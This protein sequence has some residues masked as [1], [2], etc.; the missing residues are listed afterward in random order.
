M[1]SDPR[2]SLREGDVIEFSSGWRSS[3]NVRHVVDR[4][5]A[6]FGAAIEDRP[7]IMTREERVAES[8]RKAK[9]KAAR[10]SLKEGE[11]AADSSSEREPKPYQR[12]GRIKTLIAK[13]LRYP[14][15]EGLR[16]NVA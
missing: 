5:V 15:G 16:K 8:R 10:K 11:K 13:R 1:V 3:K 6:P 2:D 4:I 14:A 12:V 9:E 7:A